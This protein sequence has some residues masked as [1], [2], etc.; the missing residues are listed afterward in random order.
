MKIEKSIQ[1]SWSFEIKENII[2]KYENFIN[3]SCLN[4]TFEDFKSKCM[5]IILR[6][7]KQIVPN[8]FSYNGTW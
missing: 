7:I 8:I 4:M 2:K 3:E 1:N 6:E 5:D